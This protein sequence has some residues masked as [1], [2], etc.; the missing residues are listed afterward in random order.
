M[1]MR[2]RRHDGQDG[3]QN[4]VQMPVHHSYWEYSPQCHVNLFLP[5][6]TLDCPVYAAWRPYATLRLRRAFC[7]IWPIALRNGMMYTVNEALGRRESWLL[8]VRLTG[9]AMMP[10]ETSRMVYEVIKWLVVRQ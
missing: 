9:R 8:V 5:W 7:R 1:Q 10:S 4:G 2:P 6:V 3:G